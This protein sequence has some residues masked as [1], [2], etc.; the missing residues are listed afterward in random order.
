[1]QKFETVTKI[2]GYNGHE[3]VTR[4]FSIL[5]FVLAY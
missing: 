1:M 3:K 5:K 2:S 4:N